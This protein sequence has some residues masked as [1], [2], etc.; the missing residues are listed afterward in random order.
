[1][2]EAVE[3][4]VER[5]GAGPLVLLAHGFGGS[6]RNFRPQTRALRPRYRCVTYDSRGH[7]R[8]HAPAEPTAYDLA[9]L[10]GDLLR[11]LDSEAATSACLGGLSLGAAVALR[12]A[13]RRPERVAA[14]VLAS[15]PPGGGGERSR[16]FAQLL[17]SDGL[18]AAGERFVWGPGS[19]LDARGAAWVK[20][21]FLEHSP[22]AL[23]SILR[24][25]LAVLPTPRELEGELARLD[26][27][28]LLLAGE[29]DR[30]SCAAARELQER[31][32]RARLHV[33]HGAGHVVNL[34]RPAELNE[35]L[36]GFLDSL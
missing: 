17:E 35:A 31:L 28:V 5:V 14:L 23:A 29:A 33:F 24:S 11:V 16:A 20:Q 6:A 8:S 3:L 19:G 22:Q 4:H 30:P 1:M 15:P 27:P 21:G 34:E 12:A 26:V 13:L 18:E 25:T 36:L 2:G 32:P 10:S 7:A 9:A